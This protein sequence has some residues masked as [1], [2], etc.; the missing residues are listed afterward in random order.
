MRYRVYPLRHR[1]RRPPWR[2]VDAGGST[3]KEF[4]LREPVEPLLYP[5]AVDGMPGRG[6]VSTERVCVARPVAEPQETE[7]RHAQ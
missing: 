3:L 6:Q 2:E 5:R 4:K 7:R 1:G